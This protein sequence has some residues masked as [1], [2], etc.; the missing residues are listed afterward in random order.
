MNKDGSIN[1]TNVEHNKKCEKDMLKD[2]PWLNEEYVEEVLGKDHELMKEIKKT[3]IKRGSAK[4]TKTISKKKTKKKTKKNKTEK[5]LKE[6]KI[7][8]HNI[9]EKKFR[10]LL[11]HHFLYKDP[12][13]YN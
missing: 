3:K 8:C 6:C 2:N 9:N 7:P 5:K 12:S 13:I 4:A 11:K 10:T 1:K